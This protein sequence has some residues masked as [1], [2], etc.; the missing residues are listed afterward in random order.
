[1]SYSLCFTCFT[2]F[3]MFYMYR[4]KFHEMKTKTLIFILHPKVFSGQQKQ[5]KVIGLAVSMVLQWPI[6]FLQV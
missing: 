4:Y 1:M 2:K 5:D 3:Y 6:Y